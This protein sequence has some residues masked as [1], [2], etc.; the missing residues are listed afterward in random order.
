M[1]PPFLSDSFRFNTFDTSR[2]S[3]SEAA[4]LTKP[5]VHQLQAPAAPPSAFPV[6]TSFPTTHSASSPFGAAPASVTWN[7]PSLTSFAST[8][9]S[10]F[11]PRSGTS[12][13]APA[14]PANPFVLLATP[15]PH[16]GGTKRSNLSLEET[17][18]SPK[19]MIQKMALRQNGRRLIRLPMRLPLPL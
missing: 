14:A 2:T 3:N 1:V 10:F 6:H 4:P 19:K 9:A 7:F 16:F 11:E 8:T 15:T 18:S 17:P 12:D 13:T 5:I